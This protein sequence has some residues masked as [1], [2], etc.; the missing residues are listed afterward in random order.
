ME[1]L[2]GFRD[3]YPEPLPHSDVW[4]ADARQYIFDNWRTT[5][6]RYGFRE[7]DGPPLEP[8]ELFTTKSGDEIVGQLYNFQDKGGREI[9]LRPE[10]TPTLARMIGAHERSYKKPIKWFAVP[11]LF[12][13][14]RQQKGRL[15]EHFQFNADIVGETDAAAD[16]ELIALLVD[17]LRSFGLTEKD[18]VI[19]L[20][21]RNAWHDYFTANGG[22]PENEYAF[23]QAIDKLERDEPE[24]SRQKLEKAGF[25]RD[26]IMSFIEKAEPTAELKAILDNLAARGMAAF[27]KVDYHVIRGLAYYTGPVFEAF[28]RV[29][30]FRAIAGGGRYDNLIK[31]MSGGKV[32][33]PALGFGMGDVVLRE[34]LAARKLLPAFDAATDVFCLIENEA[35]RPASLQ[36]I[37]ELRAAGLSVDYSFTAAKSD[38]QFKR[39]QELKAGHM[40]KLEA[41]ENAGPQA[42]IRNLKTRAEL[43]VAPAEVAEKIRSV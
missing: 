4:S 9:S 37:Q 27:V 14:E 23:Y 10:M 3:F 7:Y 38:K 24:V 41:Q 17:V 1:R 21:S 42:R 18:F 31:L 16:A 11:Q 36:L 40:V 2:P 8:L 34:L 22:Q 19:R 43:L 39:A 5:S 13:Y 28:D 33:L 26:A 15:R 12:R 29:G 6:K 32:N 35:L 20:S 30:E 25:A